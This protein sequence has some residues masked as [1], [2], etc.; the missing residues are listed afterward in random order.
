MTASSRVKFGDILAGHAA[1]ADLAVEQAGARRR[2]RARRA[3]GCCLGAAAGRR[4][5][6]RSPLPWCRRVVRPA[7]IERDVAERR[8][9]SGLGAD[10]ARHFLDRRVPGQRGVEPGLE[11]RHHA[12]RDG[13]ALDLGVLGA[14]EDQP[15]DRPRSAAGTRRWRAGRDSR[16]RGSAGSRPGATAWAGRRCAGRGR[17]GRPARARPAPR[18][19][20]TAGT[21]AGPGA[22]PGCRAAPR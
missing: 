17:S 20:G 21:G 2:R 13:R 5:R 12:R 16:C 3:S 19:G 9:R 1:A 7:R 8:H 11:H 10:A 22:A 4:P 14:G 15:L 18:A 6:L